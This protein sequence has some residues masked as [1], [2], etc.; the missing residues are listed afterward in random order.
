MLISNPEFLNP[1]VY[2]AN[3]SPRVWRNAVTPFLT[4]QDAEN[5]LNNPWSHVITVIDD[6]GRRMDLEE[7]EEPWFFMGVPRKKELFELANEGYTINICKYGHG[8]PEV[9]ELLHHMENAFDGCGDCHMFIT[10]GANNNHPS[11][12]PHYDKPVNFIIQMDG[13]TRWQVYNER[14]SH[15]IE[16][17]DPPYRPCQEELTI[18][19]DTVLTPGDVLYFPARAYHN[20]RH[21]SGARLSLSFPIW[22]PKR[23]CCS[24]RTRYTLEVHR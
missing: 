1:D 13:E 2:R 10:N 6:D 12:H 5:A 18:A 11:F 22:T 20:T 14:A 3:D 15:L 16:G 23:C 24:D 17:S 21:T 7:V 4:W 9:D 8:R 19:I